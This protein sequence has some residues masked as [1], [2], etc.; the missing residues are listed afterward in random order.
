[1]HKVYRQFW[2]EQE[3]DDL[4]AIFLKNNNNWNVQKTTNAGHDE[5]LN[6]KEYDEEYVS[7]YDKHARIA[8]G[9]GKN[10]SDIPEHF[11]N[12]LRKLLHEEW[13]EP[14]GIKSWFYM[15]DWTINRYLGTSGGKF[16]WHKDKLDFFK[17]NS[18]DSH[19]AM[20][21]K[22]SRP[23]R[24]ISISVALNDKSEYN[25][26]DF[27]IDSGDGNKTPVDLNKGDMCMFTSDT[28]HSVEPVTGDGVRYALII[29]VCDGDKHKEWNM[30]YADNLKTGQ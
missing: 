28:F 9:L 7:N 11:T 10:P 6:T 29:W 2:S 8:D 12:K 16:E 3:I 5:A 26:G 21:I 1:M 23:E 14:T 19:E 13:S 17:Y 25:N 15:E 22:N 20:F 30:H 18:D 24:E 4:F 27:T